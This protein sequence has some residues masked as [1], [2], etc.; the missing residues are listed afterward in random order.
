MS[1]PT[2]TDLADALREIANTMPLGS[3]LV[4]RL[5]A[6]RLGVDVDGW[7]E[8]DPTAP[9]A[10]KGPNLPGRTDLVVEIDGGEMSGTVDYWK[11]GIGCNNWAVEGLTN[12][13]HAI[14]RYRV[15]Q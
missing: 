6:D 4:L 11:Q 14:F 3:A 5:A 1:S 15:I 8:W 13:R 10:S 12:P 2:N 9:N 7:I